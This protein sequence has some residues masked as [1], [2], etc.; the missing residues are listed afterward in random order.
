MSDLAR[1]DVEHRTDTSLIRIHGE[2]DLSNAAA[3]S[4]QIEDALSD[5]GSRVTIDLTGARYVDSAG[6]RV[7]FRLAQRLS[8]RRRELSLVVPADSPVRATLEITGL[9]DLVPIHE[10]PDPEL[11]T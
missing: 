4:R 5:G 7:L 9:A 1:L 11:D 6:L 10:A 3:V 2:I 8:A